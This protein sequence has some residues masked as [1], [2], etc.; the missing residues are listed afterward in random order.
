MSEFLIGEA[1]LR[2]SIDR[3]GMLKNLAE[4]AVAQVKDDDGLYWL[5][6]EE[7]NSIAILFKHIS[8]N[9]RS[10]WTD[11]FTSDGEKPDRN[12]PGEFDINFRPSRAELLE[13][14]DSSWSVLFDTLN[15]LRPEDLGKTIYIRKQPHSVI[16]AILRQL[17]HYSYH[18]GQIVLLSKQLV[19]SGWKT[20]SLPRDSIVNDYREI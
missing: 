14:W 19:G 5:S 12:R 7:A 1:F 4:D 17:A 9:I 13:M 3:F 6:D 15:S 18:V 11:I 16:Q 10:R 2:H 8:G 20:L